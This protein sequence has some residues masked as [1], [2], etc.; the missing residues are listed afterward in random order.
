M[1][2]SVSI[3]GKFDN[4]KLEY[5]WAVSRGTIADGQGTTAI[6]IKTTKDMDGL[7]VT[8]TIEI[9]G[10][11]ESCKNSFSE[12]IVLPPP[13]V[14]RCVIDEYGKASWSDERLRLQNLIVELTNDPKATGLLIFSFKNNSEIDLIFS[15]QKRILRYLEKNKIQPSQVL[16]RIIKGEYQTEIRIIP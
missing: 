11:P 6:L 10:L 4:S 8:A 2:F 15:R 5:K 13:V 1:L 16:M 14:C 12:T 3:G 9:K 7:E